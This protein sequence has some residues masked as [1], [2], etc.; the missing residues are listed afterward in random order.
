MLFRVV[1]VLFWVFLAGLLVG[2]LLIVGGQTMGVASLSESVVVNVS[3]V[4]GPWAFSSATLCGVC[5]FILRYKPES[6]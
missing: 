3:E 4:V 6:E 1:E 2:G 5:A